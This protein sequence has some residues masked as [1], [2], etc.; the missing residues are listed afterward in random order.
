[1]SAQDSYLG[2]LSQVS[3]APDRL[4]RFPNPLSEWYGA[5][6]GPWVMTSTVSSAPGGQLM[7][8][9]KSFSGYR[10]QV[11]PSEPETMINATLPSDSG[12]LSFAQHSV[13]DP[14]LCDEGLDRVTETGSII[15]GFGGLSFDFSSFD[16]IPQTPVQFN[17]PVWRPPPI[18]DSAAIHRSNASVP[19]LWCSVCKI[20]L[21]TRSDKRKH[22][23]RHTKPHRCYVTGCKRKEGFGTANDLERHVRSCHPEQPSTGYKYVCTLEKCTERHKLWPR[24]DNFRAHIKRVHKDVHLNDEQLEQYRHKC[25]T[26]PTPNAAMGQPG[27]ADSHMT[28]NLHADGLLPLDSWASSHSGELE[29]SKEALRRSQMIVQAMPEQSTVEPTSARSHQEATWPSRTDGESAVSTARA[30]NKKRSEHHDTMEHAIY[31]TPYT[32]LIPGESMGGAEE[33]YDAMDP[34]KHDHVPVTIDPGS[35]HELLL[36]GVTPH[37]TNE[38]DLPRNGV[39]DLD[40]E[41][42]IELE[43]PLRFDVDLRDQA[44]VSRLLGVLERRG[45][46]E[47]HGY[48]KETSPPPSDDEAKQ[49]PVSIAPTGSKMSF[50]CRFCVKTFSRRCEL[51]KHEKR[52]D[53]P[54]G[55]TFAGCTKRFGSKNDWKRHENSQHLMREIW[56]CDERHPSTPSEPCGKI[57]GR[58]EEFKQHLTLAH[59]I[60]DPHQI[61]L[62]IEHCRVGRNYDERFWCGF[63]NKIVQTK[64][65]GQSAGME[66]FD[67]IGDHYAGRRGHPRQ[68]PEDWKHVDLGNATL[69]DPAATADVENPASAFHEV[70]T[71]GSSERRSMSSAKG[72]RSI[73]GAM[74]TTA[75]QG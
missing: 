49:E 60:K 66:R 48:K 7:H 13:A 53:K 72:K 32:T 25:P 71:P 34:D 6:D 3:N 20:M 68:N 58:R 54:F 42:V 70:A 56:K 65:K 45:I 35:S 33:L 55:C 9:T 74:V 19:D 44:A 52:H 63:C 17:Q 64:S 41:D 10:D 2:D 75:D 36:K 69:T 40:D 30:P 21:K 50:G 46:L 27:H 73:D 62:K 24:A 4:G 31:G 67:H 11:T 16:P 18:S 12:Y 43:D 15:G 14:S 37:G 57:D 51:R 26:P 8:Q 1:M 5:N 59:G 61:D 38:V 29:D 39:L 28:A 23:T 22:H 47:R